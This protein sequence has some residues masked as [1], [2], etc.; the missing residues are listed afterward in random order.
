MTSFTRPK[1]IRCA[2]AGA[3]AAAALAA[4]NPP[5]GSKLAVRTSAAPAHPSATPQAMS[6]QGSATPA[7][8]PSL[9]LLYTGEILVEPGHMLARGIAKETPD[10]IQLIGPNGAGV[11]A[12]NGGG[13]IASGGGNVISNDGASIISNDGASLLSENGLGLLSENGLGLIGATSGNLI[14]DVGSSLIGR[15]RLISPNGGAYRLAQAAPAAA[16]GLR[17]VRDIMVFAVG[18]RDGKVLA[19]PVATNAQGGYRLGFLAAPEQGVRIMAQVYGLASD[20]AFNYAALQAPTTGHAALNDSTR[21]VSLFLLDIMRRKVQDGLEQRQRGESF[22]FKFLGPRDAATQTFIEQTTAVINLLPVD[23]AKRIDRDG[24]TAIEFSSKILSFADLGQSTYTDLLAATEDLRALG[25]TF[26]PPL[27]PPLLEQVVT[28]SQHADPAPEVLALL[29]KHGV[30][31]ETAQAVSGH[32]F[33]AGDKVFIDLAATAKAHLQ[34]VF[35][36]FTVLA[37][38]AP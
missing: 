20:P 25:A 8:V 23:A 38:P 26:D 4:C 31:N 27:D 24:Q 2:L 36:P 28:M 34:E 7:P 11:V 13:V 37:S 30:P 21:A 32:Y 9:G 18:L 6:S 16:K 10:G 15:T 5:A 17:P 33:D 12:N 14:S 19:G 3:I 22:K 35:E 1:L 29:A